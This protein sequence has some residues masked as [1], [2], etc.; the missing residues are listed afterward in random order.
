MM[1]YAGAKAKILKVKES[2]YTL[3]IDGGRYEWAEWMFEDSEEENRMDENRIL[4]EIENAVVAAIRKGDM[5][6]FNYDE[7][8]NIMPLAKSVFE[9]LDMKRVESLITARME[10]V[11]AEKVVNKFVTEMGTDMKK[12]MENAT[13]REDI[14]FY[15]RKNIEKIL[16][17][18]K[19]KGADSGGDQC[20]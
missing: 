10:E 17:A 6:R 9:K 13:I 19:E 11:V 7:R 3:D 12:L 5:F 1:E 8:I 14:R 2:L 18:I 15:M 4:Q 20:P 16:D